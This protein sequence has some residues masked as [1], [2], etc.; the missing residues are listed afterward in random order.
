MAIWILNSVRL[1]RFGFN[2]QIC[3]AFSSCSLRSLQRSAFI[4]RSETLMLNEHMCVCKTID[5]TLPH[6]CALCFH[7]EIIHRYTC[8]GFKE[9]KFSAYAI[10][11][12]YRLIRR[13]GELE[14]R[15]FTQWIA[16]M[17]LSRSYQSEAI[18]A[19]CL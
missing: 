11:S 6:C 18:T 2:V 9:S 1:L 3:A 8:S 19:L 12:S 5:F 7:K 16:S 17:E 10:G 14:P 13:G 4:Q 15:K